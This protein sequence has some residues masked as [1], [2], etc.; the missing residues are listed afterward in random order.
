MNNSY[1]LI[2]I[3][4]KFARFA[5]REREKERERVLSIHAREAHLQ[6]Q[7]RRTRESEKK[8][9]NVYSACNQIQLPYLYMPISHVNRSIVFR[10]D[11]RLF[12]HLSVFLSK[13]LLFIRFHAQQIA[14]I[15]L[16]I[17][18]KCDN[19]IHSRL[20]VSEQ[21]SVVKYSYVM[22]CLALTSLC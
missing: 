6:R 2:W 13:R 4:N 19:E 11:M 16:N 14:K 22:L 5:E 8:E 10:H 20:H 1:V 12:P 7:I 18:F 3:E 17:C 15:I 21:S 9:E